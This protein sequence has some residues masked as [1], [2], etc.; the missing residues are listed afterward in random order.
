MKLFNSKIKSS[1]EAKDKNEGTQLSG[2][3]TLGKFV[4]AGAG[5][6]VGLKFLN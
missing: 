2:M 1:K 3:K 5:I 4:M 6:A